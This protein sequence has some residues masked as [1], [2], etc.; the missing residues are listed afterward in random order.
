M[1][2]QELAIVFIIIILPISLLLS[3]YTQFQINTLQTQALYDTKLTAATYDAIKAFQLNTT[4]SSHSAMGDSKMRDLTASVNAFRNSIMSA[5]SLTGYTEDDLNNYI[6]ALV[7]TLY[8][9]FYIYSPYENINHRYKVETDENGNEIKDAYTG[10][11]VYKKEDG[12]GKFIFADGN[13]DKLYGIKPYINYSCRYVYPK[14][15][16][17]PSIDVVIT[18]ALDNFITVRGMINGEYY[19]KSGYLIKIADGDEKGVFYDE[20][21]DTVT[22][23]GLEIKEEALKEHIGDGEYEYVKYNGTKYYLK[24][25]NQIIYISNGTIQE[26]RHKDKTYSAEELSF[27]DYYNLLLLQLN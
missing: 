5:F 13:G 11:P 19:D 4:N 26:Q 8:D 25:E 14:G 10:E 20:E 7:Y 18:Y 2:I 9:G 6:P 1:K 24:D 21:T 22:Y 23:N 3:E 16:A 27:Q 12:T 17:N 15:S